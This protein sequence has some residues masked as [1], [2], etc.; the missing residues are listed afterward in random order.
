MR[1]VKRASFEENFPRE[2]GEA[3]IIETLRKKFADAFRVGCR[4]S[5][6]SL[7]DSLMRRVR[8]PVAGKTANGE[9]AA[10]RR[11][12]ILAQCG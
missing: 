4:Q 8:K 2:I 10:F 5:G 12:P 3:E 7:K 11:E 1:A 6:E 9:R